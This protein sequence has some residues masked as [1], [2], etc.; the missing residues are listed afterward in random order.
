MF[1]VP[2]AGKADSGAISPGE[3]R[4]T[5]GSLPKRMVCGV[6]PSEISVVFA[7]RVTFGEIAMEP[8]KPELPLP[9]L[10]IPIL[11]PPNCDGVRS[12]SQEHSAVGRDSASDNSSRFEQYRSRSKGGAVT[13]KGVGIAEAEDAR[14]RVH[15]D[16]FQKPWYAAAGT[17]T[18]GKPDSSRTSHVN[19]RIGTT[20]PNCAVDLKRVTGSSAQ[21]K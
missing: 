13:A 1:T 17:G 6:E 19:N 14:S 21:Q 3:V 8:V 11:P 5:T 9:S 12:L 10:M 18:A 20:S 15:V 2:A 7:G 4:R 16:V